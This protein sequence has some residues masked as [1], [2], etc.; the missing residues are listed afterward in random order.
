[1]DHFPKASSSFRNGTLLSWVNR[2]S[3]LDFNQDGPSPKRRKKKSQTFS[4]V[5]KSH[6]FNHKITLL[7]PSDSQTEKSIFHQNLPFS[8]SSS[9]SH[10]FTASVCQLISSDFLLRY[11]QPP[12]LR[13]S[14]L[15]LRSPADRCNTVA[16]LPT[17]H[18]VINLDKNSNELLGLSNCRPCPLSTCSSV[19]C[20][21]VCVDLAQ[22]DFHPGSASYERVMWC[23]RDRTSTLTFIGVCENEEGV[24]QQI[25]FSEDMRA[26]SLRC[27][28]TSTVHQD[29]PLPSFHP[30]SRNLESDSSSSLMNY[31]A[32]ME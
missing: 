23:F 1:M 2:L 22:N 25:V 15:S 32:G 28:P 5:V 30:L 8:L 24:A 21:V 12:H 13:F 10:L 20:Y 7:F 17:K 11:I 29:V 4:K 27:I 26:K 16:F 9:Q 31:L 19:H 14:A 18:L 3:P 6:W